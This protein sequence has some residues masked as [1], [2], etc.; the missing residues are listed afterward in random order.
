MKINHPRY[1]IP[2]SSQEIDL[3]FPHCLGKNNA[4]EEECY[5]LTDNKDTFKSLLFSFPEVRR[6][7]LMR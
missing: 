2:G 3:S 1:L 6:D 4:H 5:I 7:G